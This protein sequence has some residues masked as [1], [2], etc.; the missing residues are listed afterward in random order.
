MDDTIRR[1]IIEL[2][3][4]MLFTRRKLGNSEFLL[5]L[6][7]LRLVIT[8]RLFS[9]YMLHPRINSPDSREPTRRAKVDTHLAAP[10]DG[11]FN[12]LGLERIFLALGTVCTWAARGDGAVGRD[13]SV[14][15]HGRGRVW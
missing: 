7:T 1:E 11:D 10:S 4:G 14:P 5:F 8:L 3:R 12:T 15:W 13:D 2:S 9:R 6:I